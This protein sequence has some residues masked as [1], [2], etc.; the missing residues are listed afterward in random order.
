MEDYLMA[1]KVGSIHGKDVIF[2]GII[3]TSDNPQKKLELF[4]DR[5][6]SVVLDSIH[7]IPK[8]LNLGLL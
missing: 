4:G 8:V 7:E 3:G 5:G 6:V 2:F 1:Q